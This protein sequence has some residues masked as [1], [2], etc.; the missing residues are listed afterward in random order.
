[1]L[2]F[3]YELSNKFFYLVEHYGLFTALTLIV[4]FL[5]FLDQ[6]VPQFLENMVDYYDERCERNKTKQD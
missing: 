1:M 6:K 2:G 3:A 5:W 4:L